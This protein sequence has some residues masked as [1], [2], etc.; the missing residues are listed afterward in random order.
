MAEEALRRELEAIQ[1]RCRATEEIINTY[2]G[3]AGQCRIISIRLHS[4]ARRNELA[5]TDDAGLSELRENN[6]ANLELLRQR[7]EVLQ[8]AVELNPL[9]NIPQPVQ[10]DQVIPLEP[11][12]TKTPV[13]KWDIKFSGDPRESLASFLESVEEHSVSRNITKEE[14]F[15]TATDLFTGEALVWYRSI[16]HQIDS[17]QSLTRELRREY[18]P[19]DYE[20]RLWEE[21]RSRSQGPDERIGYYLAVMDTLFRRLPTP[22]TEEEKLKILRKNV[23]PYYIERLALLE[24]DTTRD[25]LDFCR[26]LEEGRQTVSRFKGPLPVKADLFDYT[27]EPDLAY[28]PNTLHPTTTATNVNAVTSTEAMVGT[29]PTA[30]TSKCWNCKKPGHTFR[31]CAQDPTVFCFRCGS[32][33]TYVRNCPKCR[34]K[35][36]GGRS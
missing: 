9:V 36:A 2:E 15:S 25:L 12:P 20:D 32:P 22:P 8:E 1:G 14:L 6:S 3:D 10:P 4:L 26:R 13:F 31:S 34:P 23:D 11:R 33:G 17:W 21:I 30:T 24:I 35:N 18:Q 29:S 5:V 19:F 28:R 27:L 7:F 16:K